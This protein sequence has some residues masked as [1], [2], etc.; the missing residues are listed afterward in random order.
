MRTMFCL[1]EVHADRLESGLQVFVDTDQQ[2]K[3]G[4]SLGISGKICRF[5][6]AKVLHSRYEHSYLVPRQEITSRSVGVSVCRCKIIAGLLFRLYES[7]HESSEM[8]N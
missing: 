4:L 3:A 7:H 6:T 2:V 1:P 5:C 8:Q